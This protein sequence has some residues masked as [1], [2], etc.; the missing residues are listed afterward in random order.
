MFSLSGQVALVTGA[1]RGIGFAIAQLFAEAGAK[2]ILSDINEEGVKVAASSLS[3]AGYQAFGYAADAG[4]K[5]QL[6]MLL[7]AVESAFGPLTVLMCNAGI[8]GFHGP[9]EQAP[10]EEFDDV[11]RLNLKGPTI[12]CNLVAP[13]MAKQNGGSIVLMSSLSGLRGNTSIGS[14]AMSKAALAQLARNLA[15]RWGEANVRVN[16]ISPGLIDTGLADVFKNNP[17]LYARRMARTPLRRMG[18]PREVAAAALFLATPAGG[19]VTGHN[20]VVDGGTLICD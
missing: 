14:Y 20:L 7:A 4:D 3:Q 16:A 10:A 15:V 6:E 13:R 11:I 5:A 18:L 2:V 12:L 17:D 8:T 9:M 1:A 19:F